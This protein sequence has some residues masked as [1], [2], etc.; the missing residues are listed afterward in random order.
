MKKYNHPIKNMK[1]K[2]LGNSFLFAFRGFKELLI[3]E[4]N[5]RI[6]VGIS[7]IVILLMFLLETTLEE[8]AILLFTI[9]FV[10]SAEIINSVLERVVD[11]IRPRLHQDAK[12]IKDAMAAFV[13]LFSLIAGI[14]GLLIFIPKLIEVIN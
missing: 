8:K 6:H 13:L 5:M 4:Q 9:A 3:T 1:L 12:K 10:I 7:V 14:I 11:I 2:K